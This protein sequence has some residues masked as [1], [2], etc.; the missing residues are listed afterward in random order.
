MKRDQSKALL[1]FSRLAEAKLSAFASAVIKA[2]T[3]NPY[4][5]GAAALLATV[6]AAYDAYVIALAIA[7]DGSRMQA[8]EK[9]VCRDTLIEALRALCNEV[10][11]VANGDRVMLLSSG[12]GVSKDI[13]TP[14]V[15]EPAKNVIVHYGDN[16]GEMNVTV[17]GVKGHKGLVFEYAIVPATGSLAD[18]SAWISKP[19]ATT[20][21]TLVNMPVG[22]KVLIRIG[23][24]GPRNQLVYTAP[25]LKL[26][27]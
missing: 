22:A 6:V 21:C 9:N 8:A 17:K 7:K 27:A 20:Q 14:V 4:F 24:S 13:W 25:V 26:V 2:L 3:G 11:Y 15:I 12:F 10:N 18:D 16:S 23:I 5:A 1:S 19:S